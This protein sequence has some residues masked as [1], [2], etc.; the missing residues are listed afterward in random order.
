M[1]K[2][3]YIKNPTGKLTFS[4]LFHKLSKY[5]TFFVLLLLKNKSFLKI[6]ISLTNTKSTLNLL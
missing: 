5:L 2:N 4:R 1:D 3:Q 6:S